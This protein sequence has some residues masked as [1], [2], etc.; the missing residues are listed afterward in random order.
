VGALGFSG[1]PAETNVENCVV[2][3][4]QTYGVV[5]SNA[6]STVRLSNTQVIGN[7]IGIA[8]SG[9]GTVESY[10]TN[11]VRGN[12]TDVSGGPVTTVPRT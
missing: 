3:G 1:A 4:S 11:E 10:G 7:A 6:F 5:V 8:I 2:V 9:G 12:G